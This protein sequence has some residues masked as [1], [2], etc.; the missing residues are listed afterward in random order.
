[1]AI[2]QIGYEQDARTSR[3]NADSQLRHP[4]IANPTD[5]KK[6][7]MRKFGCRVWQ[8]VPVCFVTSNI[9]KRCLQQDKL[10]ER[11]LQHYKTLRNSKT[12]NEKKQSLKFFF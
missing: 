11:C 3:K 9:L 6:C 7:Y 8:S 10:L 1:M 2:R 12:M 5:C 4:V